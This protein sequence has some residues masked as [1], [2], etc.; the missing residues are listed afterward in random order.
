MRWLPT[1]AAAVASA[2]DL[3]LLW[4]GNARRPELSLGEP[5]AGWLALGG[6]L[7]VLGI[8]VYALGWRDAAR[9]AARAATP[10][11]ARTL[12]AFGA[13]SALLGTAIHG[14]T[15][16][17]IDAA[18]RSAAPAQDPLAAVASGG[19][20][21]LGLWAA[22][23]AC[24]LIAS[25]IFARAAVRAGAACLAL[26]T[27]APVTLALV[28]AAL[29]WTLARAFLAPAAPNLAHLVFFAACAR[30]LRRAGPW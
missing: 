19:P 21:L 2:G 7:G 30:R 5:G 26:A 22:A 13:A 3:L 15:A 10:A 28:A 24:V 25:L 18:L 16:L 14:L 29:P 6:A 23:G 1:L 8:P 4:V 27:P 20:A 17:Q 9:L 11:A 12:A